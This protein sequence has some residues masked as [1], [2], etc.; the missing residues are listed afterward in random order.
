MR[1]KSTAGGG[2]A[3]VHGQKTK[4]RVGKY[5]PAVTLASRESFIHGSPR[6]GLSLMIGDKVKCHGLL[7]GVV[8]LGRPSFLFYTS[9]L[10]FI[11][12]RRK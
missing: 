1:G 3:C 12:A 11:N 8:L 10:H 7:D 5:Q 6:G 2:G 4:A 9:T